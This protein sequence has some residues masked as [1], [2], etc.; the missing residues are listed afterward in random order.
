MRNEGLSANE[1][2]NKWVMLVMERRDQWGFALVYFFLSFIE[3]TLKLRVAHN[4][5][6]DGRLARNHALLM[7][8]QY[9]QNEQSRLLQFLIP[10]AIRSITHIS[11]VDAYMLQRFVWVFLMFMAFHWYLR[12]WLSSAESFAGVV[13]LAAIMPLTFLNDL[14]ESTPL[15]LFLFVLG[16]M[17]IRDR[18]TT[19]FVITLTIGSI[20]NETILVLLAVYFFYNLKWTDPRKI[21][22]SDIKAL[23]VL[24]GRTLLVALLPFSIFI[25]VRYINRHVPHL[26]GDVILWS[27]NLRSIW[28]SIQSLNLFSLYDARYLHFILLYSVFWLYALLGYRR[29]G[30]FLQRALWMI[31]FFM[32]PHLITSKMNEPRDMLPVGFVLIP[33]GLIFL[34][35]KVDRPHSSIPGAAASVGSRPD[36]DTTR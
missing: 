19:G 24:V 9:F 33:M 23:F 25:T 7:D 11:I 1:S 35:S 8:F 4:N 3:L 36:P 22:S 16:L 6:F 26:G 34:F 5:W 28:Y 32:L 15:L 2:G 10:E 27:E 20:T 30:L 17:A 31:P 18:N 14:M 29:S 13:F 21:K 12:K